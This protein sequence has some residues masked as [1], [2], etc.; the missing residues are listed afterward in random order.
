MKIMEPTSSSAAGVFAWK[1]VGGLAALGAIG[2]GL[3]TI[4]VMCILR[5]T[6]QA[7]WVVGII[8]T[9]MGS[10]CGGAFVIQHFELQHWAHSPFGLV[11]MLGLCFTCGLPAWALVRWTFNY[12]IKQRDQD[13]A[14]FV[15]DARKMVQG[16][17]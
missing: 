14:Q 6:T 5:P 9:V 17:K 3:A 12:I 15:D 4:V 2:A 8:S 13:I 7:E 1:L 11:A 10:V 16:G